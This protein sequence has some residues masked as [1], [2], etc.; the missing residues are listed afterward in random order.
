[1]KD[2]QYMTIIEQCETYLK[3]YGDSYSGVGRFKEEQA[4][5][6]YQTMLELIQPNREQ[7]TTVLDFGCGLSHFY[8]YLMESELNNIQYSGLDISEE[9]LAISRQKYP[10]NQYYQINILEDDSNLPKFDYIIMNGIFTQKCDLSYDAMWE[11]FT[12]LLPKV[13]DHTEIALAFNVHS[14]IVD[15]E[16]E[17]LF[18]VPFDPLAK[19]ITDRLTRHFVIRHDY[20]LYEYT[21]YVYR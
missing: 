9:F 12:S 18:H 8:A 7:E 4:L 3:T 19:F 20:R 14:K 10:D 2:R 6:S 17:D 5:F 11:Y 21:V 15:W 16:R 1:M 13:F